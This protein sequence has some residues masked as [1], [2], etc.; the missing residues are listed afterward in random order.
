MSALRAGVVAMLAASV[1]EAHISA[2]CSS[3]SST[4][5][6]YVTLWLATYHSTQENER[7]VVHVRTPS[8]VNSS[9]TA[10]YCK[11]PNRLVYTPVDNVVSAL[12]HCGYTKDFDGESVHSFP[13]GSS[14]TCHGS[15][16]S[17][18]QG[19][20]TV[21]TCSTNLDTWYSMIIP[22]DEVGDHEVWIEGAGWPLK[23]S[24]NS[25]HPCRMSSSVH[26]D[27]AFHV[28]TC[29]TIPDYDNLNT[30]ECRGN[31]TFFIG[32]S[33]DA[34]CDVGYRRDGVL[35]CEE[36][37]DTNDTGVWS[38]NFSCVPFTT[39]EPTAVP[40]AVPTR[41]PTASPPTDTPPTRVP[42]TYTTC[43]NLTVFDNDTTTGQV[44][45]L[46]Y[47]NR[48]SECWKI[49]CDTAVVITWT[50]FSTERNYDYMTISTEVQEDVYQQV[51]RYAGSLSSGTEHTWAGPLF[52]QFTTDGSVTYPGFEFDFFCTEPTEAPPTAV[53]TPAPPTAEP[54][55]SPPTDVPLTRVPGIYLACNN[56]TV[57]DNDTTT[58]QVSFLNY[59][60]RE[61]ECWKIECD[62]AV[63]ITWTSFSTERNYD[64]M[65]IS[66][67]L[68]KGYY[69]QVYRYAGSLSSGTVH[70]WD[71]PLF[72][73]FTTDGSVT[74][75][76]FEFDFVCADPTEAPPTAVPTPAPPTDVPAT[77]VP[78]VQPECVA[79]DTVT[80]P[81]GSLV[82]RACAYEVKHPARLLSVAFSG[83][84]SR[85]ATGA[86][87]RVVRVFSARTGVQ[88]AQLGCA[89]GFK[90]YDIAFSPNNS[91]VALAGEGGRVVVCDAATGVLEATLVDLSHSRGRPVT[92]VQFSDN[93]RYV[94]SGGG[95]DPH[96][97]VFDLLASD[98]ADPSTVIQRHAR[99]AAFD[100]VGNFL[101]TVWGTEVGEV[102]SV[103]SLSGSGTVSVS[104][105]PSVRVRVKALAFSRDQ[106]LMR[107][108]EDGWVRVTRWSGGSIAVGHAVEHFAVEMPSGVVHDSR[109]SRDGS[110]LAAVGEGDVMVWSKSGTLV[111]DLLGHSAAVVARVA[112]A[113]DSARLATASSDGTL[114]VWTL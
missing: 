48:E 85:V 89:D 61:S 39:A 102:T 76:G 41:E 4:Q 43:N 34:E 99:G 72:M 21:P 54:T 108:M 77:R 36:G 74:Y 69:K 2:V 73:Q 96:T 35:Q 107:G 11:P 64:Y 71:G 97:R 10:V 50:S 70:T 33:C 112:F 81:C 32:E 59:G 62:T 94:V 31:R 86:A 53:P 37:A 106:E 16:G 98:V 66:T 3:V 52:M 13:S 56:L 51:Y 79:V 104:E 27:I 8:G 15:Y 44:S 49:E 55:A 82:S 90:V 24:G 80:K 42:G 111:A 6:G 23:P 109:Y 57:F 110:L 93:G 7:G 68:F 30:E 101:A 91:L 17:R 95:S 45:F 114:I 38:Q 9:S 103:W 63:I 46:N 84:G 14:V 29:G 105:V 12:E 5:P 58:G 22:S 88:M 20:D 25:G 78:Y 92:S 18:A 1:V 83:D 26:V 75:P 60:N 65:T 47:G 67:E 40:T 28:G 113:P 19:S 87:D 100:T